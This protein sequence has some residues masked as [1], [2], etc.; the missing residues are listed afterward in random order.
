MTESIFL[1]VLKLSAFISCIAILIDLYEQK[2]CLTFAKAFK[3]DCLC[4]NDLKEKISIMLWRFIV[5]YT[6]V[7]F[8]LSVAVFF[9][10]SLIFSVFLSLILICSFYAISYFKFKI[11]HEPLVFSD[12]FLFKEVCRCPR[13]YF[14]YI[15]KVQWF[16]LF[17]VFSL[18]SSFVLIFES[19]FKLSVSV[20]SDRF[21]FYVYFFFIALISIIVWMA[22]TSKSFKFLRD[23]IEHKLDL[24]F[25]SDSCLAA[26]KFGVVLNFVIGIL[27]FIFKVRWQKSLYL[28]EEKF[29]RLI[30][31]LENSVG[32]DCIVLLQ[33][34]SFISLKD[35]DIKLS[36][37]AD[38]KGNLHLN[39]FGAYTMRTEFSVLTGIE[40]N[41]LGPY[42][43]DPYKLAQNVKISSIASALKKQGFYSICIHANSGLFFNRRMVMKNLGFDECIFSEELKAKGKEFNDSEIYKLVK[44]RLTLARKK[45]ERLFIFIISLDGHGPYKDLSQKNKSSLQVY[46]EKQISLCNGIESLKDGLGKDDCLFVYGDHIPPIKELIKDKNGYLNLRSVAKPCVMAYNIKYSSYMKSCFD[47]KDRLSL[48]SND[49]NK[50]I[51]LQGDIHA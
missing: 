10:L 48:T 24:I 51:L 25:K 16:F 45:K 22:I 49:I 32:K 2:L 7:L 50:L 33:A 12:L 8:I 38:L 18:L 6:L 21:L 20:D 19:N 29:T 40:L 27:A 9:N 35:D 44:E 26:A 11:L 1:P 28:H 34:E 39:Y 14:G 5:I 30:S 17:V 41:D 47:S 13:F 23:K 43:S 3:S 37:G 46:K 4:I 42:A 36:K 15:S 31:N